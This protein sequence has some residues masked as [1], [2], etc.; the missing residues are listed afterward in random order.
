MQKFGKRLLHLLT[1]LDITP[2]ELARQLSGDPDNNKRNISRWIHKENIPSKD[3]VHEIALATGAP[4]E[5]LLGEEGD[6]FPAM[7]DAQRI[8]EY[9]RWIIRNVRRMPIEE[10]IPWMAEQAA[11]WKP[12]K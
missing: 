12:K 4:E 5:W 7:I 8:D 2:S 11:K 9:E 3:K 6:W 10:R 1:C